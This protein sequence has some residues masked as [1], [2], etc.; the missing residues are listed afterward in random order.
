M[1]AVVSDLGFSGRANGLVYHKLT[2]I[3]MNAFED[4]CTFIRTLRAR[5]VEDASEFRESLHVCLI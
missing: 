2:R 1:V 4:E 3:R 5:I